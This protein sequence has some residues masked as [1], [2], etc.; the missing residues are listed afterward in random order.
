MIPAVIPAVGAVVALVALVVQVCREHD[1]SPVRELTR[2]WLGL[3]PLGRCLVPF[4][5]AVLV[6]YG[7]SKA[8]GHLWKFNYQNGLHDLGS[9]CSNDVIHAE[10]DY[11]PA[12]AGYAFRWCYRDLTITNEVGVCIDEYHYLP[13][14]NVTDMTAEANVPGATNME[15]VCYSQYIQ[16]VHVVTNG[17]YHV[18]GVMRTLATTNAPDK[19]DYVTPCVTIRADFDM[20]L[21][22]TNE[23]PTA[24]LGTLMN[25]IN[26]NEQED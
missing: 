19:A 5:V 22:P 12:Y 15:V 1:I 2:R 23:P 17:T 6:L 9:W 14:A 8:P 20:V 11:A 4:L 16:P 21:T 3:T 18:G 13:D 24:L 25:E 7:G 26:E 10:W